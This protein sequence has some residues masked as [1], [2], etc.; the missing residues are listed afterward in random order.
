[1]GWGSAGRIFDPI[2][3]G[4]IQAE[5]EDD[6]VTDLADQIIGLLVAEDW[7][8]VNESVNEFQD[9]PAILA[10]FNRNG[11]WSGKQLLPNGK[12]AGEIRCMGCDQMTQFRHKDGELRSPPHTDPR[13]NTRCQYSGKDPYGYL[14]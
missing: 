9:N 10:A 1:M 12:V 7:D 2:A 8:T 14:S 4:L 5:V 11:Y 3:R 6:K 13:L